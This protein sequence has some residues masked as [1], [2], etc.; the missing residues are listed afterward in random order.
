MSTS[1]EFNK[2][3]EEADQLPGRIPFQRFGIRPSANEKSS[4]ISTT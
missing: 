3:V 1:V 2:V 4:S